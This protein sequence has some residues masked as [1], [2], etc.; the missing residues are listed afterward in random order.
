MD[1]I[2]ISKTR[3]DELIH[4]AVKLE[5]VVEYI[6]QADCVN[7]SDLRMIIGIKGDK[8]EI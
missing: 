2:T 6:E 1:T 3:Y 8:D 7:E 4:D 5:R